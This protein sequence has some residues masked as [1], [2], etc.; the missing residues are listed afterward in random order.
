MPHDRTVGICSPRT[1]EPREYRWPEAAGEIL[2][3]ASEATC[4]TEDPYW[5]SRGC[6]SL[7]TSSLIAVTH[8]RT[9][10][11][12]SVQLRGGVVRLPVDPELHTL[13]LDGD[14]S[15]RLGSDV[16]ALIIDEEILDRSPSGEVPGEGPPGGVVV[17]KWVKSDIDVTSFVSEC[18]VRPYVS[19]SLRR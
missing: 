4:S 11:V 10:R 3:L 6:I 1:P 14:R 17:R 12:E 7:R 16:D 8:C 5:G 19:R 9:P 18:R 13:L 2:S 15:V